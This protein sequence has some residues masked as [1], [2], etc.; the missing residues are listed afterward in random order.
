MQD[1][2]L[3]DKLSFYCNCKKDPVTGQYGYFD[4]MA[5]NIPLQCMGRPDQTVRENGTVPMRLLYVT[6][7]KVKKS[8]YWTPVTLSRHRR[9]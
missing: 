5:K 8:K 4:K 2:P 7:S 3:C 1:N 6:K 9:R